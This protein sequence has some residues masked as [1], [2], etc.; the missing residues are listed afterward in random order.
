[1]G[2]RL[3]HFRAVI[4]LLVLLAA[5]TIWARSYFVRERFTSGIKWEIY[6]GNGALL[7][8]HSSLL[9]MG[10]FA[11]AI[12]PD[13]EEAMEGTLPAD[14]RGGQAYDAYWVRRRWRGPGFVFEQV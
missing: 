8:Q 2:R 12:I 5:A 13:F 11:Y 10:D 9:P 3:F 7:I 1:M 6:S 14:S 4:L